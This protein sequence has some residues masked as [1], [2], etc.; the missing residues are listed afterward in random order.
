MWP[1]YPIK[2]LVK[3][4]LYLFQNN[5]FVDRNGAVT[6][7]SSLQEFTDFMYHNNAFALSVEN[8]VDDFEWIGE[9]VDNVKSS[10]V[11]CDKVGSANM[12]RISYGRSS[13]WMVNLSM[14][15]DKEKFDKCRGTFLDELH[16]FYVH[17]GT[18]VC[19]TPGSTGHTH[20]KLVWQEEKFKK[21][22]CVSLGA[23]KFLREHSIGGVIMTLQ[24]GT[25]EESMKLDESCNFLSHWTVEPTGAAVW[26]N[27]D[28]VSKYA[29]YFAECEVRITNTLPMGLF[30]IRGKNRRVYY[31]TERGSY[32]C[33]LWK[34]HIQFAEAYGCEVRVCGGTGW[35]DLTSDPGTWANRAYWKRREAPTELVEFWSKGSYTGAIG[36]HGMSRIRYYLAP[37]D[38][39]YNN[40]I[41]LLN[42]EGEP[43]CYGIAEEADE[44]SAYLIHMQ[45]H[46]SAMASLG[47]LAFA[48]D[49][50]EEGRLIQ[51]YHDSVLIHERDE[52]H[53]FVARKS[54][55]ALEQPP[56]SWLYEIL[57]P[58]TVDKKGGVDSPQ[59]SRHTGRKK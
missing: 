25:W 59:Y 50:A 44:D 21:Q 34:E 12:I 31:P 33:H 35:T 20:M 48:I 57:T 43:L 52:R 53:R 7:V 46:T 49:Y 2:S 40:S 45:R 22:T 4:N 47:S 1:E 15:L 38:R 32:A 51:V 5:Q 28:R 16:M 23:E 30:P 29:T 39:A 8:I 3:R 27:S 36:H 54:N 19:I 17:M 9:A 42:K 56:G 18:G 26:F 41:I 10:K 55:E 14:W 11:I 58:C 13:R 6:R 37:D 24:N